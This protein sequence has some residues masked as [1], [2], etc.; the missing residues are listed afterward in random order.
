MATP[1][2]I[3]TDCFAW[4]KNESYCTALTVEDCENCHF[5]KHSDNPFISRLIIEND[6]SEYSRRMQGTPRFTGSSESVL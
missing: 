6:I 2:N 4:D 5:Y 3:K 1:K